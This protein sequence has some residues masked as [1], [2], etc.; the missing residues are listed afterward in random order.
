[1]SRLIMYRCCLLSFGET[2]Y[3]IREFNSD[4]PPTIRW[5][6]P[7][8]RRDFQNT[9]IIVFCWGSEAILIILRERNVLLLLLHR[10]VVNNKN[11]R[12]VRQENIRGRC[13]RSRKNN[14][15]KGLKSLS[16]TRILPRLPYQLLFA[17][18]RRHTS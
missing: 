17:K 18:R 12:K 9:G 11:I 1:M 2:T 3:K 5:K 10:V 8:S 6:K 14:T 16:K 13:N 4:L 15:K 7:P